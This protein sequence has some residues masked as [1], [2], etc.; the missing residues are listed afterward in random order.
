MNS[1]HRKLGIGLAVGITLLWL[2]ASLATGLIIRYE[3]GEAADS[4]LRVTAQQLLAVAPAKPRA[5]RPTGPPTASRQ[6]VGVEADGPTLLPDATGDAQAGQKPDIDPEELRHLEEVKSLLGFVIRDNDGVDLF[7][8]GTLPQTLLKQK[9]TQGFSQIEDHRVYVERS[10]VLQRSILI[11]EPM[12]HRDE[13]N[14]ETLIVL[15]ST[16][17]VLI[18]ASLLLVWWVVSHSMQEVEEVQLQI[19]SRGGNDLTSLSTDR[20][21]RELVPIAE[22]VNRLLARLSRTLESERNFTTNSA[23]E[24]RTPIASALAQT[25]RQIVSLPEGAERHRA[26]HIEKTLKE[27]ARTSEKLMQL[28]RAESGSMINDTPANVFPV[29]EYL[30]DEFASLHR[31]ESRLELRCLA[32]AQFNTVLDADGVAILL[33]NL[34]DNALKHGDASATVEVVV[35]SERNQVRVINDGPVVPANELAGLKERFKRSGSRPGVASDTNAGKSVT[36][37]PAG[38]GLGLAI[39]ETIANH[40]NITLQLQSPARGRTGGFEATLSAAG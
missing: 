2:L 15:S 1:I 35:D 20:M 7:I 32:E 34:I 26:Q 18:P 14:R 6:E 5:A 37:R 19:E 10:D 24:L 40:A 23:H 9:I 36:V 38:S 27:L 31:E 28:A 12:H 17:L 4:S 8:G 25:Q 29:I 3:L 30:M 39:A 13:I 22:S 11:A 16:L 33:R 21:P